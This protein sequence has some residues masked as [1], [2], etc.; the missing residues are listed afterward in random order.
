MDLKETFLEDYAEIKE[1]ISTFAANIYLDIVFLLVGNEGLIADQILITI[2]RSHVIFQWPE[3]GINFRV[4]F[5]NTS[6]AV[7]YITSFDRTQSPEDLIPPTIKT[8][9]DHS[10][11][12]ETLIFRLNER[13]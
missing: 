6:T 8:F 9:T 2:A 4:S 13:K 1:T 7:Y 10:L 12:V 11:A 3:F 5:T